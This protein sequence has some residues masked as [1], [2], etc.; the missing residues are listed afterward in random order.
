MTTIPTEYTDTES[1][2]TVWC[3]N[4]HPHGGACESAHY[5]TGDHLVWLTNDS[6]TT[7]VPALALAHRNGG[8]DDLMETTEALA[9]AEQLRAVV[10]M[11]RGT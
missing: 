6:P 8:R 10:E 3:C 1:C 2:P 11:T 5:P 7:N 9:L 4:P